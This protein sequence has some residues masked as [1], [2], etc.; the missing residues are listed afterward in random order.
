MVDASTFIAD[1]CV[2]SLVAQLKVLNSCDVFLTYEVRKCFEVRL[3]M[4]DLNGVVMEQNT[5]SHS[6]LLILKTHAE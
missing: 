6:I 5:T 3:P 1:C 4:Q 2:S